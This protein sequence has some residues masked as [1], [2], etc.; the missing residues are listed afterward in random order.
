LKQT[1]QIHLKKTTE[2]F[3]LCHLAKDLYNKANYFIRQDFFK[4]GRWI[5]YHRLNE[6]LKLEREYQALP[7]QTSQQILILLDKNWKSFFKAIK[8]WAK[9]PEKYLGKP[10]LP[11]YKKKNGES[12]IV[13]TN[14]NAKIKDGFIRFPKICHLQLIKTRICDKFHQIRI[15]P[16][17]LS[18]VLEIVHEKEPINLELDKNRILGID[19]GLRNLATCVNN[20]GVKPFVIRGGVVK[21]VNQFYNK[22]KAGLQSVKDLQR[23]KFETK[24]LCRL[25]LKRNNKIKDYFHKASRKIIDYCI[26]HDLGTIIIGYNGGWKQQIELG[27]RTNQ[28]FVTVPFLKLIQQLEYKA[29]L[30]GIEVKTGAEDHTSKCSFL[31]E[32]PIEHHEKYAGKRVSRGLFRSRSGQIINADCNG[33]YNIMKKAVPNAFA[34]GIEGVGLHPYSLAIDPSFAIE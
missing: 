8:D 23:Y 31:D 3:N 18:Y 16:R 14:Q 10:S 9:H 1:E 26:Q 15:I 33:G 7:S 28:N 11:K 32:E 25:I 6:L 22:R 29:E 27:R 19:L 4:T 12:I 30:V 2:L 20:I 17:G 34:D 13:F 24:R 5:R 21:S